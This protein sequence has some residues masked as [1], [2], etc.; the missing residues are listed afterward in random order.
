MY[1]DVAKIE[2]ISH[3]CKYF[4]LKF[5]NYA[6]NALLFGIFPQELC[7]YVAVSIHLCT[8]GTYD[9][10]MERALFLH[11]HYAVP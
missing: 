1:A 11:S 2:I 4:S 6:V 8:L 7:R 5:F 10:G 3:S 9:I